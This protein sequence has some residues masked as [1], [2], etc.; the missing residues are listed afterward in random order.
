M[1]K[2]D[3]SLLDDCRPLC[4]AGSYEPELLLPSYRHFLTLFP[5]GMNALTRYIH[6]EL[7]FPPELDA[8]TEGDMLTLG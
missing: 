4:S 2:Y 7:G 1:N 8:N 6:N 3:L 5:Y